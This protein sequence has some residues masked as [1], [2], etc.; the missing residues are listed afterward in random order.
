M[1]F[2]IF[3]SITLDH[4]NNLTEK[5]LWQFLKEACSIRILSICANTQITGKCFYLLQNVTEID[6][7]WCSKLAAECIPK[8]AQKNRHSLKTLKVGP[9]KS[10]TLKEISNHFNNLSNLLL[11]YEDWEA[12]TAFQPFDHIQKLKN[13]KEISISGSITH[14]DDQTFLHFL[15]SCRKLEKIQ[16]EF[17][18][19][20]TD[21]SVMKIPA[22]CENLIRLSIP[23]T[24]SV[25]DESLF[26]LSSLKLEHLEIRSSKATDKGVQKILENCPKLV[27]LNVND[28]IAI[29]T[30]TLERAFDLIKA[31][32]LNRDLVIYYNSYR[33]RPGLFADKSNFSQWDLRDDDYALDDYDDDSLEDDEYIRDSDFDEEEELT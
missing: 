1:Q 27:L 33:L 8:L 21:Q 11:I 15:K 17:S 19:S 23:N 3:Q 13:L 31:K 30:I 5:N 2:Y 26:S 10:A 20:I 24:Y 12:N 25:T 28:C 7:R 9:I 16:F 29:T 32:K 6:T 14:F 4:S 22:Y 18:S